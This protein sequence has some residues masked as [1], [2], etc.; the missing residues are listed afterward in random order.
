MK[1]P[2]CGETIDFQRFVRLSRLRQKQ[3]TRRSAETLE[4]PQRWPLHVRITADVSRIPRFLVEFS[5][6]M[7]IT[8]EQI[9]G[10][11]RQR[12][13]VTPRH[14]AMWFLANESG[15]TLEDIGRIFDRDHS[16]VHHARSKVEELLEVG[17]SEVQFAVESVNEIALEIWPPNVR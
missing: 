7:N 9:T 8:A 5:R 13:L 14:V 6:L 16:S 10:K 3:E 12:S 15:L 11:G 2:K 1:C 17:D 4:D